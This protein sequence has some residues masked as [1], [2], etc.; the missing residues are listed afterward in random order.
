VPLA[1]SAQLSCCLSV[2]H[3]AFTASRVIIGGWRNRS[4]SPAS[5]PLLPLP[6]SLLRSQGTTR[7]NAAR[8]PRA[9]ARP[10][11]PRP[12]T[13]RPSPPSRDAPTPSS[14]GA[15]VPDR[16][17]PARVPPSGHVPARQEKRP[18]EQSNPQPRSSRPNR[19]TEAR[20]RAVHFISTLMEIH[21]FRYSLPHLFFLEDTPLMVLIPTVPPQRP[22]LSLSSLYKLEPDLS[23]SIPSSLLLPLTPRRRTTVYRSSI[24]GVDATAPRT[25]PHRRS[26]HAHPLSNLCSCRAQLAVV[27]LIVG[28]P[29]S[30]RR[31]SW[32]PWSP[33]GVCAHHPRSPPELRRPRSTPARR[34]RSFPARRTTPPRRVH[35]CA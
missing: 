26:A 22:S 13:L 11:L 25:C 5:S 4:F 17:H 10:G 14:P 34:S 30:V 23:P 32:S 27:K 29:A 18:T 8:S 35:P 9:R 33:A 16:G 7:P 24:A 15:Q 3:I 20:P 1:S 31:P 2:S 6:F 28:S 21:C 12:K 19:A